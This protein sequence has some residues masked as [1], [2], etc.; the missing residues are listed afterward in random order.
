MTDLS[1]GWEYSLGLSVGV[2]N[3]LLPMHEH[4]KTSHNYQRLSCRH[5]HPQHFQEKTTAAFTNIRI[6]IYIPRRLQN[7]IRAGECLSAGMIC[8]SHLSFHSE[9]NISGQNTLCVWWRSA[10]VYSHFRRDRERER[11]K[12][13]YVKRER[14][15]EG[16]MDISRV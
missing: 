1:L 16:D 8:G 12:G 2:C 9:Q 4:S 10:C 7:G 14:E 15:R 3:F 5:W 6:P 11:E 13:I